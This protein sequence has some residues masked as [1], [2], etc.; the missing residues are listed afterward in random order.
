[1]FFKKETP[2]PTRRFSMYF[3]LGVRI[4][5]MNNLVH[6]HPLILRTPIIVA[7][8]VELIVF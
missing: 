7:A 3:L 6:K 4:I 5:S 2:A 8:Y 1:M